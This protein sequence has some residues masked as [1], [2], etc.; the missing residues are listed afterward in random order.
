ML[1]AQACILEYEK[2]SYQGKK[3]ELQVSPEDYP[4]LKGKPEN[5][6]VE[7]NLHLKRVGLEIEKVQGK[8]FKHE[9]KIFIVAKFS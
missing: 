4:C 3:F 8:R 1:L 7:C 2:R 9:K 5:A 6:R